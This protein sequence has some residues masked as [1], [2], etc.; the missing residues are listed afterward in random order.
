MT[1]AARGRLVPVC[2]AL[3]L[4]DEKPAPTP[5]SCPR[6]PVP[7][8]RWQSLPHAHVQ[9]ALRAC[10]S[11]DPDLD[12]SLVPGAHRPFAFAAARFTPSSAP[13]RGRR[14]RSL[15]LHSLSRNCQ[16]DR[17]LAGVHRPPPPRTAF[18][19]KLPRHRSSAARRDPSPVAQDCGQRAA[20]APGS[21]CKLPPP[22]G[23]RAGAGECA[24]GR[25]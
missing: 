13:A 5:R 6:G 24:R 11:G 8:T 17:P 14:S 16:A 3:R 22:A 20:D 12:P 19:E 10:A 9:Q 21:F 2:P 25:C 18:L 7:S 23:A 4:Q 1:L 15:S